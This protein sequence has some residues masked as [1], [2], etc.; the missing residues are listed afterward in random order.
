MAGT[1]LSY[2]YPSSQNAVE[3]PDQI[4]YLAELQ[5]S[6]VREV[7]EDVGDYGTCCQWE[8]GDPNALRT[9]PCAHGSSLLRKDTGRFGLLLRREHGILALFFFN[10][11]RI[12][13]E[14]SNVPVKTFT[15]N[16]ILQSMFPSEI[17]FKMEL[18]KTGMFTW[19]YLKLPGLNICWYEMNGEFNFRCWR[20]VVSP[21]RT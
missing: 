12:S 5:N 4:S 19:T 14:A 11:R 9:L 18:L 21:F 3:K 7:Q 15:D 17:L 8:E 6:S 2:Q 13:F 10:E 20:T 16:P 1:F